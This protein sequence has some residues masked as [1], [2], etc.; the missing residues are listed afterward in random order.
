MT[1]QRTRDVTAAADHKL[2]WSG[3]GLDEVLGALVGDD[4][5]VSAHRHQ[6][7]GALHRVSVQ[8]QLSEGPLCAAVFADEQLSPDRQTSAMRGFDQ[9]GERDRWPALVCGVDLPGVVQI[10]VRPVHRVDE[11]E[12][13]A[14]ADEAV[15]RREVFVK[16]VLAVLRVA[17]PLHKL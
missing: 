3:I 1:C 7:A 2:R 13:G 14:A 9:T 16:L 17:A 10:L 15:L 5:L 8:P 6:A 12:H 11:E 4:V